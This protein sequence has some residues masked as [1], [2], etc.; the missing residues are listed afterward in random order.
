MF[1]A[2][3][4]RR[5][6]VRSDLNCFCNRCAPCVRGAVRNNCVA[7]FNPRFPVE[8]LGKSLLSL[9][10]TN[11]IGKH[12]QR[13]SLRHRVGWARRPDAEQGGSSHCWFSLVWFNRLTT[14]PA[15]QG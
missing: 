1:K 11:D 7:I 3:V 9:V 10:F 2:W 4:D 13:I 6:L 14:S 5:A 15:S 12:L 8:G